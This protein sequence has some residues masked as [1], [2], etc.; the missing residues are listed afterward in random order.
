MNVLV[1]GE[2]FAHNKFE[3]NT[4]EFH[5]ILENYA[6]NPEGRL[7]F[8]LN[9]SSGAGSHWIV[10]A[11]MKCDDGKSHVAIADSMATNRTGE[12]YIKKLIRLVDAYSS[13]Q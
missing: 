5:Q 13:V 10:A 2:D 4:D 6:Q 12:D 7:C 1:E 8:I 9:T 11:F 3:I